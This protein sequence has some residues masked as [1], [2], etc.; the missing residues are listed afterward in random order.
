MKK[1]KD[2]RDRRLAIEQEQ[3]HELCS[4]CSGISYKIDKTNKSK[5]AVKYL[6]TY[7]LKSI[8]G[9]NEDKSPILKICASVLNPAIS[10][11]ILFSVNNSTIS[12]TK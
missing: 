9:I 2:P 1:Y 4:R 5:I 10:N 6:I 7:N 12:G 8:I 3:V 11:A